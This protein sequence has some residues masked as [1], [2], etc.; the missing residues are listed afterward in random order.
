MSTEVG[1]TVSRML[2]VQVVARTA[3]VCCDRWI[4]CWLIVVVILQLE[5]LRATSRRFGLIR[6]TEISINF[7]A[8]REQSS[9]IF[10]DNDYDVTAF[11]F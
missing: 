7:D 10:C 2:V 11:L 3:V 1:L 5:P 4:F 6:S 9:E 8:N